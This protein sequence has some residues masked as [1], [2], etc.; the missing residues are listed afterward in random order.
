MING[1]TVSHRV[2][3]SMPDIRGPVTV[4]IGAMIPEEP[5]PYEGE[6]FVVTV[7]RVAMLA[8]EG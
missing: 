8:D 3:G 1:A 4:G 6:T 5:E 7:D 2:A